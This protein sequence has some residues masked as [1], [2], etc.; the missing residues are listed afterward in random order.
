MAIEKIN[1]SYPKGTLQSVFD[2]ETFTA[3]ELAA[4]TSKK[5]DECVEIVNGVEQTAI[6]ATAIVEDM[7]TIQNQFVT[8]NSDTRAQLVNDNQE[9]LDGLTASKT[10]FE[11]D[12]NASKT[13]FETTLN[14]DVDLFKTDLN[15]S[16]T[17]FEN[18]MTSAVNDIIENAN[19]NIETSVNNKIDTMATDGTLSTVIDEQLSDI[20]Q[21]IKDI[22]ISVKK[23]GAKG[24]GITDDTIAIN[25]AIVEAINLKGQGITPVLEFPYAKHYKTTA[26]I[27][28][29]SGINVIMEAS[30]IY[31]GT[32]NIAV[33]TVGETNVANIAK[34]LKLSAS[35]SVISDWTSE[36]NISIK[37]YNNNTADI[38]I[39]N[40][41]NSTIGV[42]C[43]GSGQGFAYNEVRL[44]NVLNNMFQVDLTNENTGYGIGWCNENN[45]YGG[46]FTVMTGINTTKNRYGV[47]ITSKDLTYKNNNNNVFYKPSFE[48]NQPN[49]SGEAIPVLLLYADSNQFLNCRNEGNN[50]YFARIENNCTENYFTTGYGLITINDLSKYPVNISESIRYLPNIKFNTNV[51]NS[52][53]IYNTASKLSGESVFVPKLSYI[54]GSGGSIHK[55][56]AG[57]QIFSDHVYSDTGGLGL[58]IDTSIVKEFVIK[59][60]CVSGFAG[61]AIVIP[62]DINGNKLTNLMSNHPYVLGAVYNSPYWT[63]DWGG[64]YTT[65]SDSAFEYYFKVK[66]DVKKVYFAIVY[67]STALKLRSFSIYT[68]SGFIPNCFQSFNSKLPMQ[69]NSVATDVAG[70]V[71][72]FNSLLSALQSYGLM[73]QQ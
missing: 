50:T 70:L 25:N 7:Y 55:S 30:I 36:D 73:E 58:Y 45:F 67:G 41:T 54:H 4:K 46:K 65:P 23:Y 44:F 39:I 8:D 40:A 59:K 19:L 24:D 34:K 53:N 9:Y 26:P 5:V 52:G 18:N 72:D 10:Q 63:G 31:Y 29:P 21:N 57:I 15:T 47:R 13:L 66:D 3:L 60:D 28:I 48:L 69:N 14:N 27:V 56:N 71:T 61:R 32:S 20:R 16:K 64:A 6:E 1:F 17:T 51:F 37:L 12:L 62:Y 42:Q 22:S 38:E 49:T 11:T 33:L 35:R 68:K 2:N 43:I